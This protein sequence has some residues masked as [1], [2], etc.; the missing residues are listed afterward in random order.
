M[1]RLDSRDAWER[2][3][4]IG[5]SDVAKILGVSPYGTEWDVWTRLTGRDRES[6]RDRRSTTA[7]RRGQRWEPI[8]LHLYS[9]E[10]GLE[11]RR[12]PPWT[13]WDGPELWATCSPDGLVQDHGA[14]G[15]VEAKTDMHVDQW[16]PESTVIDAWG[17]GAEALVRPDYALQCYHL[18]RLLDAEFADLAVLLPRYELRRFRLV[19]DPAVDRELVEVLG[20]WYRRHIE[21]GEVPDVDGSAA[22]RAYVTE[23]GWS[24]GDTRRPGTP[25]EAFLGQRIALADAMIKTLEA[26][27]AV[28]ANALLAS[29]GD[30]KG[31]DWP[32]GERVTV[33]RSNGRLTCDL[34]AL[35]ADHPELG[36]LIDEYRHRGPPTAHPRLTRFRVPT[37][38]T[39]EPA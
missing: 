25:A 38:T 22:C 2:A 5:S 34:E 9:E 11:V 12:P 1:V 28:D 13:L 19:R 10:T 31:V 17:R 6:G 27:R 26:Q 14:L 16:G 37:P 24:T 32:T 7:L 36:P 8:V 20:E 3:R 39:P 33:V 30:A 35:L 29:I 21:L 15:V 23:R 4:Q 18:A